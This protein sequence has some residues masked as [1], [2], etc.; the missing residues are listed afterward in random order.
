[1][2]THIE[3]CI[4]R[5]SSLLIFRIIT[6]KEKFS[7]FHQFSLK[8]PKKPTFWVGFFEIFGW[9]FSKKPS[10]FYNGFFNRANPGYLQHCQLPGQMPTIFGWEKMRSATFQESRAQIEISKI[11]SFIIKALYI[12]L[13]LL[14]S[15]HIILHS[16]NVAP[17][18]L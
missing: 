8:N 1:M 13:G 10:G 14:L 5:V 3:I 7:S 18:R 11:R 17:S 6:L 15:G 4:E 16:Y 9:V 12:F 2:Y